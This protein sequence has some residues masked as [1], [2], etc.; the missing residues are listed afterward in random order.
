VEAF[1]EHFK[2]K[3]IEGLGC[4]TVFTIPGTNIGISE[5]VVVTWIVMAVIIILT[6]IFTRNLKLIPTGKQNYIETVV[7]FLNNF[8][9]DILGEKGKAF[10][11]YLGTVAVFLAI[12]N[13]AGVF[14][15]KPP[16]KDFN[17]T[18]ALALMSIIL[19]EYSGVYENGIKGWFKSFGHPMI[20]MAPMNIMEIL[21]R[22][23]SLCM[24]LFG[25]LLVAFMVLEL[26]KMVLPV[27]APVVFGFYFDIFDG[28]IQTYIFVFLTTLFM[29]EKME[30]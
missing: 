2:E 12:S 28:L 20:I 3:L 30:A 16:T 19:I 27:V 24:R 7:G 1:I 13:T 22:P 23:L 11:P 26:V 17:V 25:I 6:L 9:V 29:Q 8:V 15:F 21:I 10:V 14:G 18:A 4:H 5:S